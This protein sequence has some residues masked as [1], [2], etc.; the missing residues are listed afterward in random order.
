MNV[1]KLMTFQNDGAKT[2]DA[3]RYR[4]QACMAG[5]RLLTLLEVE[6]YS[7]VADRLWYRTDCVGYIHGLHVL[8]QPA[9]RQ[10]FIFKWGAAG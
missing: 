9:A 1:L 8:A 6:A 2:H 7:M 3:Y 4:F 5:C 10:S